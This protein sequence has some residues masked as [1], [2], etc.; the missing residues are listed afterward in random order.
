MDGLS[1][2]RSYISFPGLGQLAFSEY[3]MEKLEANELS[4]DITASWEKREGKKY[5]VLNQK[6]TSTVYLNSS[7]ILPI[8]MN[9]E[10]PGYMSNHKDELE[11]TKQSRNCKSLAWL[12]VIQ[13]RFTLLKRTEKSTL[14]P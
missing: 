6:Y 12:D 9:K 13:R 11:P 14:Q 5:Y 4:Q 1:V 3:T 2:V 8:H 7:P 10:T